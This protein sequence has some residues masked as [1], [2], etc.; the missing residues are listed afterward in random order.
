[1]SPERE[2]R[3]MGVYHIA[4]AS[5][6]SIRLYNLSIDTH[7]YTHTECHSQQISSNFHTL[8]PFCIIP[9]FFPFSIR[10]VPV[11]LSEVHL[12]YNQTILM[13]IIQ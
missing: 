1:M 3:G 10:V 2:G 13:I 4:R 6:I 12:L 7:I 9:P 8:L 5:I 11:L